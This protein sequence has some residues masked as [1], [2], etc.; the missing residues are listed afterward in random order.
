MN[1]TQT[2]I[3]RIGKEA[4]SPNSQCLNIVSCYRSYSL[5][6]AV[7]MYLFGGRSCTGVVIEVV[8]VVKQKK[9]P[10]FSNIFQPFPTFSY[11][12]EL[13]RESSRTLEKVG[14]G[15]K[16]VGQLQERVGKR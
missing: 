1:K 3:Q 7:C 11:F 13:S 10:T 5:G 12:L 15:M 16:N 8:V 14:K 4:V 6:N 2:D 9:S